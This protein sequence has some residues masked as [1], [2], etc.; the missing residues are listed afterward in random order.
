MPLF[1]L[2][3][4]FRI[5]K[6]TC[7]FYHVSKHCMLMPHNACIPRD[8]PWQ[9][10]WSVTVLKLLCVAWQ[11]ESLTINR[12]E[13]GRRR[14]R[15]NWRSIQDF[16][17]GLPVSTSQDS[18]CSFGIRSHYLQKQNC[19]VLPQHQTIQLLCNEVTLSLS[20]EALTWRRPS[21]PMLNTRNFLFSAQFVYV[22]Y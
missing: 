16:V 13:L 20:L 6:Y 19:T 12:K 3:R 4:P 2:F 10:P 1:L 5:T 7:P 22:G 11:D 15:R 18:R 17:W 8:I 21:V 14:S 9:L